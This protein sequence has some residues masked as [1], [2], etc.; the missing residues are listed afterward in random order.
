MLTFGTNSHNSS[1][2][3][4]TG[5]QISNSYYSTIVS[6]FKNCIIGENSGT[7]FSRIFDSNIFAGSCN[8]LSAGSLVG[9]GKMQ[10]LCSATIFA[11]SKNYIIARDSKNAVSFAGSVI[12]SGVKN[13]IQ[14]STVSNLSNSPVNGL[15][16]GGGFGNTINYS[17]NNSII[18]NGYANYLS[19]GDSAILSSNQSSICTSKNTYSSRNIIISSYKSCMY[20]SESFPTSRIYNSAIVSSYKSC[21]AYGGKNN[22]I[23]STD[24]SMINDNIIDLSQFDMDNNIII[25]GKCARLQ[26][27]NTSIL[28]GYKNRGYASGGDKLYNSTVV[29]GEFN[30]LCQGCN[31]SIIGGFKNKISIGA[32]CSAII[33]GS[34]SCIASGV[35]NSVNVGVIGTRNIWSNSAMIQNIIIKNNLY[36][37]GITGF[38]GEW[39]S[40]SP[41]TLNARGGI[42]TIY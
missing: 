30:Y 8:C 13:T 4:S 12:L 21:I 40:A 28:G 19:A 15:V 41:F 38:S 10:A 17:Y 1:I 32:Y 11:G 16:I 2:F 7:S 42:I 31:L 29:G 23:I 25:G 22:I 36:H 14:S 20:Q 24:C 35:F 26:A 34:G 5:S 18:T 9:K 33:G 39:T 6:G 37:R 27:K 3:S